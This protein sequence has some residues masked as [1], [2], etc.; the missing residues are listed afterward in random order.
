MYR[1][2]AYLSKDQV[3]RVFTWDEDGNRVSYDIPY[4][5][6]FYIEPRAGRTGEKTSLYNTS[7]VKM[8]FPNEYRRR[9]A[10][11]RMVDQERQREQQGRKPV[12]L[13]ENVSVVQQFLIDRYWKENDT[14]E[15]S[16]F[17]IKVYFLDIEKL[18]FR[19]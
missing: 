2:V 4:K 19:S 3:V 18:P 16:K 9:E 11:N 14:P 7:L 13:F 15:F 10:V 1:N 6:Y 12:R 5:P 17:P 8:E